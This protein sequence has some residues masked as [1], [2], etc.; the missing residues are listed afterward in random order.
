MFDPPLYDKS[1]ERVSNSHYFVKDFKPLELGKLR[2][3]AGRHSLKLSARNLR[4][5][6]VVDVHSIDL[7]LN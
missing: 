3:E 4:G 6:Q 1:K 5:K 7:I 2:L